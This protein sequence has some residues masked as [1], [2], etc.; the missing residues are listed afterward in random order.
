MQRVDAV[1]HPPVSVGAHPSLAGGDPVQ[2]FR[3]GI[4]YGVAA[5]AAWAL[6]AVYFHA[7]RHVSAWE[8]LAHRVVW[9]AL[10]LALILGVQRR[11]RDV[12]TAARSGR[13]LL[14]LLGSTVLIA[15]NWLTFFLAVA[16]GRVLDASLGYFINPLV[17]VVLGFVFLRERLSRL[18]TISVLLAASAVTYL[19][20]Q[21][22]RPP[23]MALVLALTFGFYGLLRKTAAVEGL[24]GLFMETALLTPLAAGYLAFHWLHGTSVFGQGSLRD[25]V[26]LAAAGVVTAI[27]LLW[28]AN[29]ARRLPLATVGFL[30]Y[31]APSGQ[32]LLAVLAFGEPFSSPQMIAFVGIWTALGLYSLD[33]A[34]RL[35]TR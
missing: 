18:Q 25:D 10:L 8:V 3:V 12:A 5:Y 29:A 15:V 24:T 13:T 35:R 33:L 7:V 6:V 4:L 31:I 11:W 22:G 30:Q 1:T 28:F 32:F 14:W 34:R 21:Y 2:R 23:V 20:V 19:T 27:P 26:L 9:S 17:N 16:H